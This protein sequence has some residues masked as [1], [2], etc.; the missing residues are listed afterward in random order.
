MQQ[1]NPRYK[2]FTQTIFTAGAEDQFKINRDNLI[3][4]KPIDFGEN[5]FKSDEIIEKLWSGY[6]KL[7]SKQVIDTF[8]YLF[9]KFKKG[10][11]VKIQNNELKTFLPFSNVNFE[12]EFSHLIEVDTRYSSIQEFLNHIS[13]LTGYSNREMIPVNKWFA[14]NALL[15]YEFQHNE[16]DNNVVILHDMFETLCSQRK[17]PD[18]EFFVNRRDFPL[19]TRNKTEPYNNLYGSNVP[20]LSH[21]YEKY[22]PILS[23]STSKNYAD[24]LFPTYED[25]ARATYQA[26]DKTFPNSY[27]KYPKIVSPLW[28]DK[29]NK[30]VFRG[31][32]TG[33]GTTIKNNQRLN[34]FSKNESISELDVGIT[35]WNLRARKIEGE[36]YLKTIE[37]PSYPKADRLSLQEQSNNKY[38]LTLEGH[39]AAYRLSYELSSG[40]VILLVDSQWKM[41]YYQFL[42][43]Y[44]HYV[45][46]KSDLS[47]LQDQIN[48]CQQND[49]KCQLI[50]SNAKRFYD[51][52]LG[53]KGILDFLQKELVELV[54]TTGYYN[55]LPDILTS[56][57]NF[58]KCM[59]S[60]I[61]YPTNKYL[62]NLP[63]GPRNIGRLDGT[64]QV[65]RSKKME[66][67]K[68]VKK[69]FTNKSGVVNLRTTNGFFL[70][71][72]HATTTEKAKESIHEVFIGLNVVNSL[73]A[74]VPNFAY[75][76]GFLQ[77]HVFTE[78]V[79]GPTFFEWLK[80]N[81]FRF[82][83]YL[84]ILCQINLALSLAQ[85]YTGFVHYDLYPWNVIIQ[86][87]GRSVPFDYFINAKLGLTYTTALIPIMI[88]YGK[89]RAVVFNEK[90]GML[91]HGFVNLFQANPIIDTMTLFFSSFN[92]IKHKL[93]PHQIKKLN[94]FVTLIGLSHESNR[95]SK[96][97]AL[98]NVDYNK[99][100]LAPKDFVDFILYTFK[101]EF[102]PNLRISKGFTF[103][104]EL[105]NPI[106]TAG[107]MKHGDENKALLDV[108]VHIDK[109]TPPVSQNE[110][111]KLVITNILTRRMSWLNSEIERKG[112]SIVKNKWNFVKK[113][114]LIHPKIS[115]VVPTLNYPTPPIMIFDE[116]ITPT[117][118]DNL[119]INT[120]P[121]NWALIWSLCNE[122]VLFGQAESKGQFADFVNLNSFGWQSAISANNTLVKIQKEMNV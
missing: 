99:K 49:F 44:I 36:K 103:K 4:G 22:S 111:Y 48:W 18:I 112:N 67:L 31:A 29:K 60:N 55:Y 74:K 69:I 27:K 85:K 81:A 89:S 75:T 107:L 68:F 12:N 30:A 62:F 5:L 46:I 104:T 110:F 65:F 114:F 24:I 80:S 21:K 17:I 108:I 121:D 73:I 79:E 19:L 43:P 105:G 117:F 38:I 92:I 16:G 63:P 119:N 77:D 37:R 11:F 15:R 1:T 91:D 115:T 7:D 118:F 23:G 40:S 90:W 42:F 95:W 2:S 122:A 35:S 98:F 116:H 52:H 28:E 10:I 78:Y 58:E 113:M 109:S 64:L 70:A 101:N 71:E 9:Y 13:K 56:Q 93:S 76:Y 54:T 106:Q 14:N 61:N 8:R 120:I 34:A 33:A 94:E 51:S 47:N 83:D 72:K 97:G 53:Q 6:K 26:T 100:K 82:N 96:Y 87:I 84:A 86:S 50:A 41:W 3:E 57:L 88:D 32:T 20:L 102:V 25:W 45:P 59:L 39:V 66:D